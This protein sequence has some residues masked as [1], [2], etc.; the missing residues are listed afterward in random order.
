[1]TA[2][3]GGL[4]SHFPRRGGWLTANVGGTECVLVQCTRVVSGHPAT[5]KGSTLC[6]SQD[7]GPG[8]PVW[9]A[10]VLRAE[11]VRLVE[12]PGWPARVS[13]LLTRMSE[14]TR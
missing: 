8:D 1:M 9:L 11:G 6:P 7:R 13:S 4:G 5:A 2:Q 12:F 3:T 14:R 10:D